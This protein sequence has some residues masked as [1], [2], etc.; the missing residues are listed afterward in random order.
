[1][2]PVPYCNIGLMDYKQLSTISY[3]LAKELY[4][5]QVY[6]YRTV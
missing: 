4:V 3:A 2:P 1:M 6:I 5:A